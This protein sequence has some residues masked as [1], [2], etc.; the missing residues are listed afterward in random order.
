MHASATTTLFS[1][2]PTAHGRDSTLLPLP[3]PSAPPFPTP[4]ANSPPLLLTAARWFFPHAT[5]TNSG[6]ACRRFLSTLLGLRAVDGS[7]V[8]T[9][10]TSPPSVTTTSSPS[11]LTATDRGGRTSLPRRSPTPVLSPPIE[12]S[13]MGR[14]G[15]ESVGEGSSKGESAEVG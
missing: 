13:A 12:L 1:I 15:S 3:S 6:S 8:S 11:E 14:A 5:L 9:S 2:S 7:H 10:T 4:H